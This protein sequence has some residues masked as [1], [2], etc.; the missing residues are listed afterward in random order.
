MSLLRISLMVTLL[1]CSCSRSPISKCE[2][3]CKMIDKKVM[4][5]YY[6][7]ETNAYGCMC[8]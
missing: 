8:Y 2:A 7:K 5:F 1:C 6:N 3:Q 4:Q